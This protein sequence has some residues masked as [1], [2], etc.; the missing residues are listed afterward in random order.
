MPKPDAR[1]KDGASNAPEDYSRCQ[2]LHV[3]EPQQPNGEQKQRDEYKQIP[4]LGNVLRFVQISRGIR[5]IKRAAALGATI[6][7]EVPQI[8]LTGQATHGL[9]V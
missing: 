3:W 5:R 9:I 4:Q 7:G 2:T 6:L 8:V 1:P